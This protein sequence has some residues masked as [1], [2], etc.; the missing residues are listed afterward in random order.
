[1]GDAALIARVDDIVANRVAPDAVCVADVARTLGYRVQWHV[2]PIG[3]SKCD[4]VLLELLDGG[5]ELWLHGVHHQPRL[6][7]PAESVRRE[8][9]RLT[10]ATGHIVHG[11]SVPFGFVPPP[12]WRKA[13]GTLPLSVLAPPMHCATDQLCIDACSWPGPTL[14]NVLQ[15]HQ[16]TKV[17]VSLGHPWGLALHPGRIDSIFYTYI[18]RVVMSTWR[19]V[20]RLKSIQGPE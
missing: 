6:P 17:A 10:D 19:E 8:S 4:P 16:R 2:V 9:E 20:C 12:S 18:L 15:I 13:L 11:F 14:R 1:M 5:D 7:H 3:H